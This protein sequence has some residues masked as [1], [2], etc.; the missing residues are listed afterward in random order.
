MRRVGVSLI[1]VAA[2]PAG[3]AGHKDDI[4]LTALLAELGAGAPTGA[5]ISVSQVEALD[6]Q[7]NYPADASNGELAGK[8][9]TLKS[10]AS[11][12]SGHATTVA[13]S[14]CGSTNGV[15][16]GMT[17]I[18]AYYASGWLQE[19]FLRY[20]TNVEPYTENRRIQNHSWVY[21]T[22][23][24]STDQEILRRFD[25]AIQ[26]DGFVAVVGVNNFTTNPVPALMAHA[27]NAISV[28]V[29]SGNHSSGG[30][31]FDV[32]GRIKPE[33]VAP[34]AFY[35]V[36]YSCGT[37]SG[38]AAL[39]LQTADGSSGL[40]N[41]RANSEV[42]KAL[43]LAGA[44]KSPFP[45]WTRT[46]TQP[47]D[48][49]YGAGQLNIQN[50]YHLLVAGEYASSSSV[51][52]SNR[53]WDFATSGA[54]PARY[55]FDVPTG[56]ALTN[57]SVILTWNRKVSDGVG[58]GFGNL[59]VTVADMNLRLYAATGFT[60]GTQ[61]DSSVSTL[62]NVEHIYTSLGPG[63]YALEVTSTISSTDYA[64][65]WGGTLQA[66][67]LTSV[68]ELTWGSV[69]PP[70]GFYP[71]GG[72]VSFAA[73]PAPYFLFNHWSG[74]LNGT[75]NPVPVTVSSNLNVTALF[76]ER[77]T[78]NHPTPYWW[79]AQYGYTSNQ[80]TVV[81]NTGANGYPLWQSYIAGLVPTNP[82]SQL[83][84]TSL[85]WPGQTNVLMTW[86]T[87]TGRVYTVRNSTNAAGNYSAL[88]GA[89][90]L[91]ASIQSFTHPVNPAATAEF[92]RLEVKKP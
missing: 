80:E 55:F 44:T 41:A 24:Q 65:A 70:S 92:F 2:V 6:Q 56:F 46:P 76:A 81:T 71:V 87:V 31:T 77:F 16:P 26:R 42:I 45:G 60:L 52:V 49:T 36:S 62:Q 74:G 73:T 64:L 34:S 8:T 40:V 90:D 7:G 89:I 9:V 20:G 35:A 39:L 68:N 28:G 91:P 12:V 59:Q 48:Q 19:D 82:A 30:T 66:Q 57:F 84:F 25:Y 27:Y 63:R 51:T 33:I 43:L 3:W 29:P 4:G 17:Q 10:G 58:S 15:A 23:G 67:I 78:T 5:G 72:Q 53:G 85:A 38:A 21:N 69:S 32:A 1:L 61:L 47:L 88:P 22:F 86:E 75:N 18:D 11:G 14:Y 54:S 13:R 50:S 37:V 83:R 79:L